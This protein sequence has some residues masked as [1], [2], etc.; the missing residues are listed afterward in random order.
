MLAFGMD[1]KTLQTMTLTD[2][3]AK[4]TER[5]RSGMEEAP[6]EDRRK[7]ID[8]VADHV[9][10]SHGTVNYIITN[11]LKMT[12]VS[13]RWVP[14]LSSEQHMSVRVQTAKRFLE[15]YEREDE[16]FLQRIIYV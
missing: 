3:H 1:K 4:T 11:D 8:E 15:R 13:A 10:V 7:T 9:E 12:K 5:V 6:N 2:N 16:R 14:R